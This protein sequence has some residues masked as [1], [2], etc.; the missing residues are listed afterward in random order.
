M[1]ELVENFT[2]TEIST[3]KVVGVDELQVC[4]RRHRPSVNAHW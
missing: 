1:Y 4:T 3:E 2:E